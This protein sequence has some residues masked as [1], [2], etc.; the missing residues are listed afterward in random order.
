MTAIGPAVPPVVELTAVRAS[1]GEIEVLHGIDLTVPAGSV[2]ALLG[3]NGAGKSTTMKVVSGLLPVTSGT[4]RLSGRDVTG[5]GATETARLGVCAV[6]EGRGVFPNLTVRDNLWVAAGH[7]C[8]RDELEQVAY[9][10]FPV[11]GRRRHQLAGS[12][13]GG[14]QQM[15]AVSRAL[16]TRPAVLLLDELSM[17]LAPMVVT[18]LYDVVAG[19][20][21]EGVSVLLAEQFA[22]IAL[23]IADH[24][25]LLV[26][27]RVAQAGTPADIEHEL[28]TAY[29][30]G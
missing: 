4:L 3:P 12:M 29:L 28:S 18:G 15:L 2:V 7:R 14:E 16:G 11:L 27:G 23:P 10:R 8:T 1:Y 19:L 5:I 20:A 26:N 30:G 6:P 21:A 9:A 24:A 17:G 25:V 22:R 13:S